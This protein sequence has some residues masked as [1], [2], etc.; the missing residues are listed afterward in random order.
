MSH[1]AISMPFSL[2]SYCICV[3][4]LNVELQVFI[5]GKNMVE[6]IL[7]DARYDSHLLRVMQAALESRDKMCDFKAY[8]SNIFSID[9]VHIRI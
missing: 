8:Q 3:V 9:Y 4:H 1:I 2:Y 5:H 6:N 7:R